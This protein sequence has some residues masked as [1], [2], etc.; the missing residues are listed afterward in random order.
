VI[1][2]S[3]TGGLPRRPVR[4]CAN[5]VIGSIDGSSCDLAEWGN[6]GSGASKFNDGFVESV[7]GGLITWLVAWLVGWLVGWL[8][9]SSN[10]SKAN[11]QSRKPSSQ[12]TS[13]AKT[14][15]PF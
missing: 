15:L 3:R 2:S 5:G 7:I 14:L 13:S 9:D 12:T 4:G 6:G 1:S 10:M 11:C 8:I